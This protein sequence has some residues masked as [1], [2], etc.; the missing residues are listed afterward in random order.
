MLIRSL[1]AE[2]FRNLETFRIEP[3]PR[4]NIIEGRN[5]QGKTNL[6][7]AVF[8]LGAFR[9]PRDAKHPELVRFGEERAVIIGEIERRE[10]SRTIE[11]RLSR[12]GKKV[13]LDGK[14]ITK[15]PASFMH[16]S[17]VLFGPD[18][19]ELT[20]AGPEVRRRFLD[21]ATY[22]VWPEHLASMRAYHEALKS[23]NRLLRDAKIRGQQADAAVLSAFEGELARHGARIEQRRH[24]FLQAFVPHFEEAFRRITDGELSGQIVHVASGI[25]DSKVSN[26]RLEAVEAELVATYERQRGSDARLG[27]TRSGPHADE[28]ELFID[29]R[30]ART[31]ASQGQHRAFVLAMKI[32]EL[33]RI[34]EAIGVYPIFLLDDVSSELDERRN[35]LLM[36]TLDRGG[37]QVFITTTD[38]RWIRVQDAKV[39]QVASGQISAAS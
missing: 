20:K 22:A 29:E 33:L 3:G 17:A 5:G 23:R 10:V 18:D 26:E 12:E 32:A 13:V 14:P 7:E 19:L 6:L 27:W 2:N 34:Q 37:G 1:A 11:I 36:E 8:M 16:L 35:A 39:W 15:L 4:F 28:L 30:P 38:R 24:L 9:S 25:A 21:R 31:F